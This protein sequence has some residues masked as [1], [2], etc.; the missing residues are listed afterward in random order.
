[1]QIVTA[2]KEIT[3][4]FEN[5]ISHSER[6]ISLMREYRSRLIADVVTGKVDVRGIEVPDVP[7]EE[8]DAPEVNG[9]TEG[10]ETETDELGEAGNE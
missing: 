7:E 4:E 9:E 1:M 6:E 8:A 3:V 10:M 2:I 5:T